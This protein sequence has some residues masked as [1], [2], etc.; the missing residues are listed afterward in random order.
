[1]LL[2]KKKLILVFLGFVI[3]ANAANSYLDSLLNKQELQWLTDNKDK[4]IYAPNPN[5]PPCD[6]VD[7]KGIHRGIVSDYIAIFEE[8]LGLSFNL[9]YLSS[10]NEIL[11]G[12]QN[13]SVD[14][15]GGI[16]HS[17]DRESYLNFTDQFL[18]IPLVLI[19]KKDFHSE[20]NSE[21]FNTMKIAC[22]KGYST[23]G[24][25]RKTYPNAEI[26]ECNDDL[27][28]MYRTSMGLTDG[29]VVDLMVASHLVETYGFSNLGSAL[30][31]DFAW[32]LAFGVRKD[33]P[34]LCSI[35]NKVLATIDATE[36]QQIFDKWI[37]VPDYKPKSFVD[38]NEKLINY[39]IIAVLISFVVIITII[40]LLRRIIRTK[41]NDL[42]ESYRHIEANEKKYRELS[43]TL[44]QKVADRTMQ[45]VELNDKLKREMAERIQAEKSNKLK[46]AFIQN[47]SHEI[48]TPMNGI[49]GFAQLLKENMINPASFPEHA[50]KIIKSGERLMSVINDLIEISN[51]Q[52]GSIEINK[53]NLPINKL[54]D[55]VKDLFAYEA[56]SKQLDFRIENHSPQNTVIHT[57]HAVLMTIFRN[58][59]KNAIKFTSSGGITIGYIQHPKK[60]EFYVRDTGIGI[61]PEK[62]KYIFERF[63]QVDPSE[64]RFYEGTGL[65]LAIA[66]SYCDILDGNISL[67][68]KPGEGS[69]FSFKLP[70]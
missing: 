14:F 49:L 16:H 17:T 28:A 42:V 10:W 66:K 61:E 63:R 32:K 7:S 19:V 24:Y 69:V 31:L 6:F 13:K 59:I 18:S 26:V 58:L 70:V 35:L 11:V 51:I 4:I 41:T 3:Q 48:R 68:S 27:D 36:R 45:L 50:N 52:S 39:V 40:I 57:D 20:V 38:R 54:L 34:E 47:L 37:R 29:A 23:I 46:T 22:T 5:W 56:V 12:L 44:E 21:S 67:I 55:E 53:Q 62:Q 15:V 64:S 33:Y 9:T 60:H 30:K 65:G 8:K 1:M 2:I 25:I 43:Q